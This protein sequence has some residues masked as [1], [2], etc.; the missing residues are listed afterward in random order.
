MIQALAF[1]LQQL[2]YLPPKVLA[3]ISFHYYPIVQITYFP[4]IKCEIEREYVL[5]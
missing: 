5:H 3:F 2:I 4:G 1:I